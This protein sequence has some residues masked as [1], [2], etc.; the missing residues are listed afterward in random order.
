M[1]GTSSTPERA[2]AALTTNALA[3]MMTISSPN[4]EKICVWHDASEC[5]RKESEGGDDIVAKSSPYEEDHC[6][7]E[8]G[9]A[10]SLIE[11]HRSTMG[12]RLQG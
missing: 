5:R 12:Q 2:T 7:S 6:C 10:E 11:S 3:T 1:Q 8:H 9:K 4:P